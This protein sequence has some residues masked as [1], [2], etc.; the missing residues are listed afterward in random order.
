MAVQIETQGQLA[1]FLEILGRRRWQ[2]ALPA[3][4]VL[5]LGVTLAVL[6]PKKY[7]VSTQ[8]EVRPVNVNLSQALAGREAENAPNQIRAPERIRALLARLKDE[9]YLALGPIDQE[10][11]LKDVRDDL[12]VR[13]ERPPN[14]TSSFV[15]IEYMDMNPKRAVQV[16][17]ALRDDWKQDVMD[18]EKN[19]ADKEA[20]DL[21]EKVRQLELAIKAE[22]DTVSGLK[23][24]NNIS[25][26]QAIPGGRDQRAEDP[27]Y[28][29]LQKQKD[30]LAARSIALVEAEERVA[31]LERQLTET[32]ERLSEAQL[33][34][35]NSNTEELAS[36][37]TQMVDLDAELRRFKPPASGYKKTLDKR[38]ELEIK[39]D[40]LK[41][42]VTRSEL[43]SVATVNPRY[44][45]LHTQLEAA[46]LERDQNASVKKHLEQSITEDQKTVDLL[47]DVYDEIRARSESAALMRKQLEAAT[48]KRDD[49][50]NLARMLASRLNDP[51]SV[52]AEVQEPGNPTE[53]NPW[54][55]T[56]FALVAG[57]ALGLSIALSAEY[58]RNCFRSVHDISRVMVAP[59]LGTIG[60]ILTTRQRRL[61][62]LQRVLVGGLCAVVIVGLSFVTFAWARN[63][64][65][66]SPQLRAR[67]E[68]L[69]DKLR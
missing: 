63:P 56:A 43:T 28:Q 11:F 50:A 20:Q 66:L 26:T 47:Y 36:I 58:G 3:L 41:K 8:I 61:R 18:N 52:L 35:G 16:L 5:S 33:L 24:R 68:H 64:E 12:R 65:L 17:K 19:K 44:T 38:K 59:V 54:L 29:R 23:Q 69:R 51:F 48:L 14:A 40:A 15:Q 2:M 32:P 62:R 1:E 55:I 37:E 42:L 34:A 67:I 9:E 30:E 53:P 7:L 21:G 57:M 49:K 4:L 39:R 22:E 31:N 25:A 13:V 45:Q 10:E 46:R 27:E 60:S 6:I